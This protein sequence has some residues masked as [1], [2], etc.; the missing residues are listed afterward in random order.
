[1]TRGIEDGC[2]AQSRPV[3][4]VFATRSPVRKGHHQVLAYVLD[5]ERS[6]VAGQARNAERS[7]TVRFHAHKS[8]V[9]DL[10]SAVPEI[11]LVESRLTLQACNRSYLINLMTLTI[12]HY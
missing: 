9:E 7:L 6:I 3:V 5:V 8:A 10:D 12:F 2:K 4:F 11:S 1:M